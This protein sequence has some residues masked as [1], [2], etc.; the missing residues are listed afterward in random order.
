MN[1]GEGIQ[2]SI[3]K[4]QYLTY[5]SLRPSIPT[6]IPASRIVMTMVRNLMSQYIR[7]LCP[8]AKGHCSW[9]FSLFFLVD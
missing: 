8:S 4:N 7:I 6:R 5:L 1:R 3:L 2:L 9:R